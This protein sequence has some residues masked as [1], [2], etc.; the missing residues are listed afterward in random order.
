M[1][2]WAERLPFLDE[3]SVLNLF[4]ISGLSRP[5]LFPHPPASLLAH[6]P[7]ASAKQKKERKLT[8]LSQRLHP[9]FQGACVFPP[10]LWVL[11]LCLENKGE[12]FECK[13]VVSSNP[14]PLNIRIVVA[15]PPSFRLLWCHNPS[16]RG[17]RLLFVEIGI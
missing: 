7:P 5:S 2:Q 4:L 8:A 16:C 14:P 13:P 17:R 11:D 1:D 3:I 6:Q 9:S 12:G 10:P 15:L